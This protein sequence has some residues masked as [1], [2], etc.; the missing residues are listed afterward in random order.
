MTDRTPD[1][2]RTLDEW[3]EKARQRGV[4]VRGDARYGPITIEYSNGDW[5]QTSPDRRWREA[6]QGHKIVS[7]TRIRDESGVRDYLE[8][9]LNHPDIS[10]EAGLHGLPCY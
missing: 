5:V 2:P 3:M 9:C 4:T 10:L 1:D 8:G 7:S 6:T